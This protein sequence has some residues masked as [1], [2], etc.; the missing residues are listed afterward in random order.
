MSCS[1][2]QLVANEGG[3][4]M[5]GGAILGLVFLVAITMQT[6]PVC[7]NRV[8]WSPSKVSNSESRTSPWRLAGFW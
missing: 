8:V 3:Q 2:Y 1:H 6:L 7:E 5:V 4:S